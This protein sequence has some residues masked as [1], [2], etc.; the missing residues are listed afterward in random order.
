MKLVNSLV[1]QAGGELAI[2]RHPGV[3]YAIRFSAE[4]GAEPFDV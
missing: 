3:T 4:L 2:K 1:Q